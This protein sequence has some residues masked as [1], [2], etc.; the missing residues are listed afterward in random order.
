VVSR[1]RWAPAPKSLELLLARTD[2]RY[3]VV[4]VDGGAPGAVAAA[5]DRAATSGRVRI[6]RRPRF[7]AGNEARNLGAD[8][9]STEW[10]AFVENDSILSDG[11][12][13]E[14]LKV[15]EASAAASVYPAYLLV[16]QHGLEVHGLGCDLEVSGP[17]GA[18]VIRETQAFEWGQ[19]WN[20]IARE[21]HPAPRLQGEPHAWVVRRE[22]LE[23]M[24]GFDEHLLG[25]FDHLDFALQHRALGL[26]A[27][28]VPTATCIYMPP[29]P[30]ALR[31]VP[32]FA[33]RWSTD[34][35]IRSR[36]RICASWG[37]DPHGPRW[38]ASNDYRLRTLSSLLTGRPRIDAAILRAAVPAQ[39][40]NARRWD[41]LRCDG[42]AVVR[43]IGGAPWAAQRSGS[44]PAAMHW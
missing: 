24:G 43:V 37:F 10:L 3:P 4:V 41:R 28:F 16:R 40:Y 18:Q 31:D 7:L 26:T 29:P 14:L 21:L 20:A 6:V 38:S 15:G 17:E 42:E 30:L 39:R 2:E 44:D 23:R 25:W 8:G 27:W 35:L 1:D 36:D 34:W 9:A 12:L 33:L 22:V 5:F 13:D 19:R 11:W 32:T